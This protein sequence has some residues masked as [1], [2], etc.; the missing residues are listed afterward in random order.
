MT[1][2]G[3]HEIHKN[4]LIHYPHLVHTLAYHAAIKIVKR[5]I[6]AR[7]EK[8][9][10]WP[11]RDLRILAEDYLE[12]NRAELIAKTVEAIRTTPAFLSLAEKEAKRRGRMWPL[13]KSDQD[14]PGLRV[15]PQSAFDKLELFRQSVGLASDVALV[16]GL[17]TRAHPQAFARPATPQRLHRGCLSSEL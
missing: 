1:T 4:P 13:A 2:P 15:L 17:S 16:G 12:A 7:G 8:L 10:E 3:V 14:G 9:V 5:G 11:A 6:A